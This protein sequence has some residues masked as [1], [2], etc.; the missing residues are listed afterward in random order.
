MHDFVA[1]VDMA[2]AAHTA[3]EY[4][5][6]GSIYNALLRQ[7]PTNPAVNFMLGT[8]YI[9]MDQYGL[10]LSHLQFVARTPNLPPEIGYQVHN[11]IGLIRK[12]QHQFPDARASFSKSNEIQLHAGA[13]GNLGATWINHGEPERALKLLRTAMEMF[14]DE[15]HY[16]TA[17]FWSTKWNLGLALLEAGEYAEGWECYH[18]A[19]VGKGDRMNRHYE[20]DL[21]A[22]TPWWDGEKVGTLCINGEQG[23]GDEIM[24]ATA[25]KEAALKCDHLIIDCTRRLVELFTRS[26]PDAEVFCSDLWDAEKRQRWCQHH[27]VDAKALM[28]DV[29][30][31]YRQSSE[32]FEGAKR[33]GRDVYLVASEAHKSR[34]RRDFL[35]FLPDRPMVLINWAGGVPSTNE[36]DRTMDLDL[37]GPIL[38][39]R[40]QVNF[41]SAAY[42]QPSPGQALQ[43]RVHHWSEITTD[44]DAMVA[45]HDLA[46]ITISVQGT[47]VHTAGALGRECWALLPYRLRWCYMPKAKTMPWYSSVDCTHQAKHGD[48]AAVVVKTADRLGKW[49]V[50]RQSQRIDIREIE[51]L[52]AEVAA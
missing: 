32:E 39:Y 22:E 27:H 12:N 36:A 37:W 3:G 45:L 2:H 4:D 40:D 21:A 20:V 44:F 6:A 35:R 42:K 10:A 8:L 31:R 25:F 52:D 46:D 19:G 23:L 29:A 13:T 33:D 14:P 43:Y 41:V 48:W 51:P 1:M 30:A 26:F 11:N 34:I 9:S 47:T 18:V 50:R 16:D 7:D 28:G 49:L 17:G 38:E 15:E 24:F 5:K